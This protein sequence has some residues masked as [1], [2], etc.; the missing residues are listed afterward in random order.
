MNGNLCIR[1]KRSRA[2]KVIKV[3]QILFK[4]FPSAAKWFYKASPP[5]SSDFFHK[6]F[7]SIFFWK[8]TVWNQDWCEI[9]TSIKLICN[10]SESWF[11]QRCYSNG[12][13]C[14]NFILS[15]K[16]VSQITNHVFMH[17]SFWCSFSARV[18]SIIEHP[19]LHRMHINRCQ[20]I[21]NSITDT[22]I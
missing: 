6:V 2:N 9:E 11:S 10:V 16:P 7:F 4:I 17:I 21:Q 3:S 22:W 5:A 12:N 18:K 1:T 19:F 15:W 20:A 8:L 13:I 14:I